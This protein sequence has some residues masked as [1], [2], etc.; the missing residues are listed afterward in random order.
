M[1]IARKLSTDLETI[2]RFLTVLGSAMVELNSNQLARPEFF[3]LAHTF[4]RDFI[5]GR[6][7]VREGLIIK[8]LE[9]VGFPSDEG[10]V[11]FMRGEQLKSHEAAMHLIH[12][13]EQ[14][15]A[16]DEEARVEVGWAASEYTSTVRQH[17]GRL[18]TLIFPLLEQ[19]IPIEAE[20]LLSEKVDGLVFQDNPE[21]NYEKYEKL[22]VSLE[23]ELSDWR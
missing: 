10:P 4:I 21:T 22:V 19:N 8:E 1:R 13:V 18:K 2:Q 7:F 5:E 23:E 17:L 11:G 3:V 14:W 15:K 20:H 16:G 12:A 9:E 6:F